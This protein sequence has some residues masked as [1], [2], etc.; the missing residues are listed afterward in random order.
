MQTFVQALERELEDL[1]ERLA[2]LFRRPEHRQRSLACLK[3]LLGLRSG[4]K[5]GNLPPL[6]AYLVE[7]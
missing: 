3:G 1:Q 2:G 5:V 6:R 7:S 4:R